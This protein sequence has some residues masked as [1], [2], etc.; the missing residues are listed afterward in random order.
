MAHHSASGDLFMAIYAGDEARV[1]ALLAKG[2]DANGKR[3]YGDTALHAACRDG[4]MLIVARL[5]AA[6]ATVDQPNETDGS[7][8]LH[9]AVQRGHSVVVAHLLGAGAAV[10]RADATSSLTPLHVAS[11]R[12][13][14]KVAALLLA[15]RATVDVGDAAGTTPLHYAC[16]G[17]HVSVVAQLL[18]AGA[19]ASPVNCQGDTPLHCACELGHTRVVAHLLAAGADM[20]TR[21]AQGRTPAHRAFE[22]GHLDVIDQLRRARLGDAAESPS[23]D[24]QLAAAC[25]LASTLARFH[26]IE[27]RSPTAGHARSARSHRR[28]PGATSALR[29]APAGASNRRGYTPRSRGKGKSD[30]L[31]KRLSLGSESD[32]STPCLY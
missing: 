11:K 23:C 20:A 14:A 28:T 7:T 4:H 10:N 16:A 24:M 2:A 8:P 5:L 21:N 25:A 29:H 18:A 6:G 30:A 13:D 15:G 9:V 27:L 26:E 12:G 31:A 22:A 17:G 3:G 1:R 19:P 32:P